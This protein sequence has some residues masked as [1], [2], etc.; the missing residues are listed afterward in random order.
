MLYDTNKRAFNN[1]CYIIQIN[2]HLTIN[3]QLYFPIR[4]VDDREHLR[5]IHDH[6]SM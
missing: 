2:E 5:N 3:V 1:Q 6:L 4:E